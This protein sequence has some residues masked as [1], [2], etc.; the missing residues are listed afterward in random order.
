M[1]AIRLRLH[2]VGK[3]ERLWGC[4]S[5]TRTVSQP[6]K[7]RLHA[8][9]TVEFIW[10]MSRYKACKRQKLEELI[11]TPAIRALIPDHM[12]KVK[13]LLAHFDGIGCPSD[14]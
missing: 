7:I 6:S 8:D 1:S 9:Y 14:T 3:F 12:K 10:I 13:E 2:Y 4:L 5:G 11:R